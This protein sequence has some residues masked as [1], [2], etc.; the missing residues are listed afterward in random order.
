MPSAEEILNARDSGAVSDAVEEKEEHPRIATDE[1][2]EKPFEPR[3]AL[4]ERE[5]ADEPDEDGK[6][7]PLKALH[8]EREKS[9]RYTDEVV[10]LRRQIAE[11]SQA[12]LRQQQPQPQPQEQPKPPE[13]DWDNPLATV[14]QRLEARLERERQMYA[15]ELQKIREANQSQFAAARHGEETVKAAY[16]ALAEARATDPNWGMTYTGIMRAPD[17]YEALVQWHKRTSALNEVGSDLDAY[18]AKIKAEYLEELRNGKTISDEREEP[19]RPVAMPS[20]L[21]NAR[22][23]GSRSGPGWE[24]PPSIKEILASR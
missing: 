4:P 12:V 16:A 3:E 9:R 6:Q 24:G 2:E 14:D 10:D 11:L 5:T 18:K 20:N 1:S 17:Q 22:S 7:V 15:A 19:R 21:S 8:A 13:F 23:V